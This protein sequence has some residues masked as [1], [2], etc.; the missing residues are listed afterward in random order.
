M[1]FTASLFLPAWAYVKHT[2]QVMNFCRCIFLFPGVF[3][4]VAWL[5]PNKVLPFELIT[6]IETRSH[7]IG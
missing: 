5:Y 3:L 2:L 7:I 4:Q 6:H 1:I